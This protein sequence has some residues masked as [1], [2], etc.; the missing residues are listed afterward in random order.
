MKHIW[1]NFFS[2]MMI[3]FVF[4]SCNDSTQS[5]EINKAEQIIDSSIMASGGDNYTH[6][7]IYFTFR[8]YRMHLKNKDGIFLY[9]KT[10]KDSAGNVIVESLTNN[11]FTRKINDTKQ[12]LDK[13]KEESLATSLNSIAYFAL[14]PFKL[15]DPAVMPEFIADTMFMGSP[16][17]KIGIKFKAD[18]EM[19]KHQDDYCYW[20]NKETMLVDF[21]AY[22]TGGPRFRKT[23]SRDT[24]NGIIFQDYENYAMEDSLIDL[25]NYDLAFLQG[26]MKL[27]STIEPTDFTDSTT[28]Q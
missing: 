5:V 3:P 23:I 8:Q 21:L 24:S 28:K 1:L 13:A 19:N 11:S 6:M 26:K 17:Y 22:K 27:L 4:S 12:I 7:D 9:E 18:G 10:F 14:L 25:R 16:Y 20:I 2:V 15:N